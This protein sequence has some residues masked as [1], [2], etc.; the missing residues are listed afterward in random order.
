MNNEVLAL[1]D[2]SGDNELKKTYFWID[3]GG[4][5]QFVQRGKA[6]GKANHDETGS[7]TATHHSAGQD[8]SMR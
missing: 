1:Q 5:G 6:T 8:N 3:D 4:L 2:R 7:T